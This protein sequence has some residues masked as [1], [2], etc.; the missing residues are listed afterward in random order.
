MGNRCKKAQRIIIN[1]HTKSV[2]TKEGLAKIF[3]FLIAWCKKSAFELKARH[4]S[5]VNQV[6]NQF[7]ATGRSKRPSVKAP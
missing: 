2:Q 6:W 1:K 5:R 7:N 4:D 3:F